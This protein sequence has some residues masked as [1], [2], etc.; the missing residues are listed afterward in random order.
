MKKFSFV[1]VLL[2][3]Q[4]YSFT[5]TGTLDSLFASH[6][7]TAVLDS[8]MKDFDL[9]MDSMSAPK[10]FFTVGLGVGNGFFSFENK[11]SVYLS[12]ERKLVLSPGVGYFHKSG[13]GISATAY[14]MVD[15]GLNFYQ[16]SLSPSYDL[17]RRSFS[18]G[19]SYTRYGHKD[20]VDF[21][22]TPVQ[23]EVFGYFTYKAWWLRPSVN[24]AYGW[25]SSASYEK[26][27]RARYLRLLS[28]L[29][30]R[31][32]YYVITNEESVRDFSTTFSVRKNFD[33]Y[34]V[35]GKNDNI[36][37]TPVLM[38]S[39]GTQN[40]GFNTS[41]SY[42]FSVIKT[43]SL[44]SS[45]QLSETTDFALQSACA[46]LKGS[47]MKGKFLI[48]PQVLFDYYLPEGDNKLNIGFSVMAGISF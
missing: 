48:Q 16:Y 33:W 30:N 21:Y 34:D 17:I 45:Q 19:V 27:K 10:S 3:V 18:T 7:T 23:N 38:L 1:L 26:R 9:F 4:K 40:F 42:N 14:G 47:Y 15:K 35:F 36:T 28:Q 41:Y 29:R 20:S 43:N 12:S 44:P 6:D 2:V 22:V 8:L 31:N 46:I 25:G 32:R 13:L 11:N 39:A 24:L 5:Q 37:F